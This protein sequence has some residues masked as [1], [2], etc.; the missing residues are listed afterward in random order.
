[1]VEMEL[2]KII[3]D[4]KRQD[5]VI[6]LK[7]KNGQRM[8][9]IVIGFLEA[10]AIKMKVSGVVPPRPLTHDLLFA[11]IESLGVVLKKI[12]I[13]KLEDNTFFAKLVLS[14][15]GDGEGERV[16]DARPSDCIA[17]AVRSKVP[18]FVDEDVVRRAEVLH[19][20]P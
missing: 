6:V 18:I 9:P 2:N 3:I 12:I 11:V 19:Q 14:V 13:D 15:P 7:E 17:L 1:M 4:E 10:N 16:I 5:Q 20:E 8:V